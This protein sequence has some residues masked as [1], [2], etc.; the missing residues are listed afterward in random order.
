M[1]DNNIQKIGK[2]VKKIK[3]EQKDYGITDKGSADDC[4]LRAYLEKNF[5]SLTWED[6]YELAYQI[7]CAVSNLH[8][9]G[10]VHGD[11]HSGNVLIHQNTVEL[12]DFGLSNR[13]KK[14]S[15]QQ[16]RFDTAL[17]T[18][19]KGSTTQQY[20]L[21]EKNDV[22]GIGMILWE[23]SSGQ[24]PFKLESCD[25]NSNLEI[26]Q[27]YRETIVSD[28]PIDYSNLFIECWDGEPNNRPSMNQVVNKFDKFKNYFLIKR[29]IDE[30]VSLIFKEVN[31][32][33]EEK[34]RKQHVLNYI[35]DHE[36]NSQ[37][38][39]NW[40]ANNQINSN[41]IYLLEYLNY[42][43]IKTCINKQKAFKLYQKA[44]NLGNN[45]AQYNLALMYKEGKCVNKN[46]GKAFELFKKSAEGENLSGINMLGYCYENGIGTDTNM[47][48]AFE[49]YH[50][51][52]N[53][54]NNVA[55][56]NLALMYKEGKYLMY[57]EGKW[58]NKYVGRAF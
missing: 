28:T 44:A 24:P 33:K 19:P 54:G 39:C 52:A 32:G 49:L 18:D 29:M 12:A 7:V 42:H 1:A 50:K 31:E 11:L 57:K 9:K 2:F 27:D 58:V 36:I 43:G 21:N 45:I 10:I 20:S 23:I 38:I 16:T 37:E 53:L 14:V 48:K 25:G 55:Q 15:E 26:L 51:A 34:V 35:D 46:D 41:F 3:Q 4:S 6:K 8:E 5:T 40:L 47:K 22:C 17:Y 30:F 13:M 56:Y